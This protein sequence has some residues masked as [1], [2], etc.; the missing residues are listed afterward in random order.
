[1]GVIEQKPWEP[2]K[3]R[4]PIQAEMQS[5]GP[6]LVQLPSLL[7]KLNI[8]YYNSHHAGVSHSLLYID[9]TAN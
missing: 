6:A 7:G 2:T 3:R 1:M 8:F 4:G 5:P 9:D